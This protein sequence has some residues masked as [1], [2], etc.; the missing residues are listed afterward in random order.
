VTFSQTH[1]VTLVLGLKLRAREAEKSQKLNDT[2]FLRWNGSGW[3]DEFG[4]NMPKM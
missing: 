3:P 2:H 4:E 1:L